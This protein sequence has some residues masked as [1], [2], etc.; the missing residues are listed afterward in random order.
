MG[1]ARWLIAA[2]FVVGSEGM[3]ERGVAKK[4]DVEEGHY[5]GKEAVK[6]VLERQGTPITR[7]YG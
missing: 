6:Q 1:K 3:Q 2:G 5:W 7:P 4:A